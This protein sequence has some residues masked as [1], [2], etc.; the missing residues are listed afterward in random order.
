MALKK[1]GCNAVALPRL[2]ACLSWTR[3]AADKLAHL[4]NQLISTTVGRNRQ[5]RCGEAV[6]AVLRDASKEDPCGALI[7]KTVMDTRR[8]LL[9]SRDRL[10]TFFEDITRLIRQARQGSKKSPSP[11]PVQALVGAI[12]DANLKLDVDADRK[13]LIVS[14]L[15]G[16][17]VDL[18]HPSAKVVKAHLQQWV[19]MKIMGKLAD[20][21]NKPKP[22]RKVLSGFPNSL[23]GARL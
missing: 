8:L 3:L 21:V 16:P 20:E 7:A 17:S 13:R 6:M 12:S 2:L 15:H 23:T 11:G 18:L 10:G 1:H 19:R 14:A 9:K 5:L 22:R 4:R